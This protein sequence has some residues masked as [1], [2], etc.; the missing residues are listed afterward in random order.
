MLHIEPHTREMY[1]KAMDLWGSPWHHGDDSW[2]MADE[3]ADMTIM[4]EQL[5]IYYDIQDTV[6]GRYNS[7]M[8]NIAAKLAKTFKLSP[9]S[10]H[11]APVISL[12]GLNDK[13]LDELEQH[14]KTLKARR[15]GAINYDP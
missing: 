15:R 3:I 14:I 12:D 1:L 5:A 13:Q 2:D 10:D 4:L 8:A 9:G 11:H 6:T 7:K